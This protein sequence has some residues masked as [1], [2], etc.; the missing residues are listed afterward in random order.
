MVSWRPIVGDDVYA[1]LTLRAWSWERDHRYWAAQIAVLCLAFAVPIVGI[2]A[3]QAVQ[4]TLMLAAVAATCALALDQRSKPRLSALTRSPHLALCCIFMMYVA[5]QSLRFVDGQSILDAAQRPLMILQ[6]VILIAFLEV[7][8][9]DLAALRLGAYLRGGLIVSAAMLAALLVYQHLVVIAAPVSWHEALA[10]NAREI[11]RYLEI[12][13]ILVFL[14]AVYGSQQRLFVYLAVA[15]YVISLAAVGYWPAD[16]RIAH[17]NSD[18]L[19]IGMPIAMLVLLI[20]RAWPRRACEAVFGT[21]A[22]Y[23]ALAPWLHIAAFKILPWVLPLRRGLILDRVEIWA[24]TA[25][26]TL[27]A[28]WHDLVLGRGREFLRFDANF[29]IDGVYVKHMPYHPHNMVLQ[30]WLDMGLIGAAFVLAFLWPLYKCVAAADVQRQ[31]ALLA[32]TVMLFLACSVTHSLWQMWFLA[33]VMVTL[34]LIIGM[35]GTSG[36]RGRTTTEAESQPA[37]SN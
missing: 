37:T 36:R 6:L 30:L 7:F 29:A 23:I 15:F 8:R 17:V 33:V 22:A 18:T 34:A 20:A 16:Q 35:G 12:P 13:A 1:V 10:K 28:S 21:I 5:L 2:I 25:W 11:N 32:C 14:V 3:P 27:G 31:P 26:R 19:Q 4:I 24:G 9:Q